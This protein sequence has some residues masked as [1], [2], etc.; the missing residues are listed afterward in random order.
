MYVASLS[1]TRVSS[2][3]SS[4]KFCQSRTKNCTL[5]IWGEREGVVEKGV[6]RNGGSYL[7]RGRIV[8]GNLPLKR[9]FSTRQC[10]TYI[11]R[12]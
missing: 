1:Y 12:S 5:Y 3:H 10:T 9:W 2:V 8:I 4:E 11:T 7:V 6:L